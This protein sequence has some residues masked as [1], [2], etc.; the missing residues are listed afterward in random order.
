MLFAESFTFSDV[1]AAFSFVVWFWLLITAALSLTL[2]ETRLLQERAKFGLR[3][4]P[5]R[6][7][8]LDAC[9]YVSPS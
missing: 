6:W 8:G 2:V 3:T 5:K 7:V 4:V 1:F 9:Q